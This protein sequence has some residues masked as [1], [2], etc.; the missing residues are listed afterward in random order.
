M[1][2]MASS[3][4]QRSIDLAAALRPT[5]HARVVFRTDGPRP[6]GHDAATKAAVARDIAEL[7][8][9]PFSDDPADARE[10]HAPYLVPCEPI[11]GLDAAARLGVQGPEDLF[12]GVVPQGFMASKVITHGLVGRAAIA[13]AG[14]PA[15]LGRQLLE[16]VLPGYTAFSK[17]DARLAGERL[18]RGGPVRLKCAEGV[19][20]S[21]QTVATNG[22]ELAR[23]IDAID[24][25]LI[26]RVGWVLERNLVGQVVTH[27]VGAVHIGPWRAAYCGQQTTTV[28]RRGHEVYGGSRLLVARGGF[29]ELLDL[30]LPPSTRL[31]VAQAMRYDHAARAACAGMFA[32][33][34][35]YDVAQGLDANGKPL[36]GVLEQ[37][38]RIGGASG[39]EVAALLAF[40]EDPALRSIVASTH[41]VH[42]DAVA[43]PPG[44]RIHYDAVDPKL[45]RLTKYTTV[46]RHGDA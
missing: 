44:A 35:N 20:G 36:S 46:E 29:R 33:R 31:A 4:L 18:L 15:A 39:A 34:V 45:G 28:D 30:E 3:P 8:G 37:S 16:V 40:K 25:A 26:R 14:W 23:Q 27:S 19:G 2:A 32:S 9:L 5:R 12:G 6:L 11:A 7:L 10:G 13:P 41:E 24:A 1:L 22:T 38:W 43:V 17:R 42:A 21:G